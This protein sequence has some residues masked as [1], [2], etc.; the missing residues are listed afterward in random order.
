LQ[1]VQIAEL[2]GQNLEATK[3]LFRRAVAKLRSL[4]E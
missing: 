2:T 3:S 1:F 4:L